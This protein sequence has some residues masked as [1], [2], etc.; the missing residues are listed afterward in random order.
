MDTVVK[1]LREVATAINHSF[2][3]VEAVAGA[4]RAKWQLELGDE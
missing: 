4:D 3:V 1:V 2:Q